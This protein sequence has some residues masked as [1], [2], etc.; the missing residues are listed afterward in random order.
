MSV[1]TV[2]RHGQASYM[3]EDYD[4]LSPT[5]EEQS[6][7]LGQFWLRQGTVFDYVFRGPAKRHARTEQIIAEEFKSAG[8]HWPEA[9]VIDELDEFDAFQ[10]LKI[11]GPII[12]ERDEHVRRLYEA[13]L[14]G[15]HG[16][17]AGILLERFFEET[18]RHWCSGEFDVPEL[19]SWGA[20]RARVERA[21]AQIR[22]IT[23]RST[24]TVVITSG[25]PI[26]AMIGYT[27]EL[28]HEKAV[29]FVWLSRNSSYS[30][31]LDSG[32][33]LSLSSFNSCPHL[34][35]SSLLT[36]R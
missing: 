18:A 20:F 19:E 10:M 33:R 3:S 32:E 21:L 5:G 17:E 22:S 4:K 8:I 14:Q 36:Y 26:A 16:P 7:R 29:E 24:S 11:M 28:P 23:R 12:V 34:D 13:F 2:V 6:R 25:G 15:Q 30:E 31:F 9:A 27:L 1:L 35:D